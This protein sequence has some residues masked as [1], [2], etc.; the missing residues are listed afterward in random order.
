MIKIFI[1]ILF[2][3]ILFYFFITNIYYSGGYAP[4]FMYRI[5]WDNY[6]SDDV[7]FDHKPQNSWNNLR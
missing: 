2:Y 4:S 1:F 3:F 6:K 7:S 5:V